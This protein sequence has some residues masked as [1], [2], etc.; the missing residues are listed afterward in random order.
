MRVRA[1]LVR[2]RGKE[3]GAG[4]G[5]RDCEALPP[6]QSR[7][8]GRLGREGSGRVWDFHGG[9]C[10]REVVGI[11]SD[12][13]GGVQVVGNEKVQKAGG[14]D[15]TLRDASWHRSG[16]GERVSEEA[17]GRPALELA[18]QPSDQIWVEWGGRQLG[19]KL[20]VRDGVKSFG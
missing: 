1:G 19:N 16:G 7:H 5:D 15:A 8:I 6:G 12:E 2:V 10:R 18:G 11:G 4:L 3:G 9:C 13:R 14:N 17:S 20:R